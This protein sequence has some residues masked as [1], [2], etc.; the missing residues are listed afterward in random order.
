MDKTV[1]KQV[2]W[3]GDDYLKGPIRGVVL[4][5]MRRMCN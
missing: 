5:V 3:L 2:S 4:A 1:I